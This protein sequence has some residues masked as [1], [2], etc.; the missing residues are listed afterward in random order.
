MHSLGADDGAK[1]ESCAAD[2]RVNRGFGLAIALVVLAAIVLRWQ[3]YS[4][5]DI[6]HADEA[7]QYLEQAKRLVIG[8]GIVPWE[9]RLD[10]R[11]S[12]IPQM[13]AL[14]Y[15]LGHALAPG[16][17]LGM[18]LVR[19]AAE[20]F[21]LLILPA[22]WKL[23]S[24]TSRWHG[25]AALFAAAV[26]YES[27]LFSTLLLSEVLATGPMLMAAA[28]LL[29]DRPGAGQLRWAGFLLGVGVILRLQY[30]PFAAVLVLM[31]LRSDRAMW[32]AL[33]QG[34]LAA[35]ALAAIS[36]LAAGQVPLRWILNNV[37]YNILQGRAARFGEEGP[38]AYVVML[39][40]HLGPLAV[41]IVV[42]ALLSPPRYRPLLYAAIVCAVFHSFISHKEYRFIWIAVLTLVI[43]AAIASVSLG[44]RLMARSGRAFGWGAMAL[45][46]VGW[47]ATSLA[48]EAHSGG[49]RSLRGGSPYPL[50][51]LA[52]M[53][54]VP[55]CGIALPLERRPHIVP[56]MLP[57]EVPLYIIP[58]VGSSAAKPLPTGIVQSANVLV[59]PGPARAIAGYA[60]G[61]CQTK[62]I[63]SACTY[64]RPGSCR[65][66]PQFTY[67]HSLELEG[68]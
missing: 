29:P 67:Q 3:A 18:H 19:I 20:A 41:P 37:D 55:A 51:A 2:R 24:L 59:L 53:R 68:L 60:D 4:P 33:I 48:A 46:G 58:F 45:L 28:L 8:T 11:N 56:A 14:P 21:S 62:G 16:T 32:L 39:L 61:G 12:L 36:D 1:V 66:D 34:G 7:M 5:F 57:R 52:G 9:T 22:A 43:L 54:Q 49:A 15:A 27:V 30:A 64:V 31:R 10:V 47:I 63:L 25:L 17:L 65:P 50:A 26:W 35:L 38:F 23:G 42:G 40:V 6:S 44:E 13:L